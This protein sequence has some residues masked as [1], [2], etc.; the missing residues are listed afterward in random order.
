[1]KRGVA[2][3]RPFEIIRRQNAALDKNAD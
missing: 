1:M 3:G 2:I